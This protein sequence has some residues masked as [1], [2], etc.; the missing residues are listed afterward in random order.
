MTITQ[1]RMRTHGDPLTTAQHYDPTDVLAYP[2]DGARMKLARIQSGD[3]YALEHWD[4][5]AGYAEMGRGFCQ[6]RDRLGLPHDGVKPALRV[7]RY[8]R[9]ADTGP[10]AVGAA[11]AAG[12]AASLLSMIALANF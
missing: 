2:R 1:R 7:G 12:I 3:A 5:L 6:R 10:L 9:T 4:D 8:E 11:F